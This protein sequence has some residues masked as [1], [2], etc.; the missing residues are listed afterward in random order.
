MKLPQNPSGTTK[1]KPYCKKGWFGG[2]DTGK[3]I[4][5]MLGERDRKRIVGGRGKVRE[6]R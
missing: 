2:L 3:V 6:E 5:L 1:G 4:S